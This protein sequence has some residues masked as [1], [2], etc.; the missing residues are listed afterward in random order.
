MELGGRELQCHV[1]KVLWL[2]LPPHSQGSMECSCTLLMAQYTVGGSSGA[3]AEEV[4]FP[5]LMIDF[6]NE[7][8]AY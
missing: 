8:K 6:T 3:T 2:E 7:M 4:A 5:P 1:M